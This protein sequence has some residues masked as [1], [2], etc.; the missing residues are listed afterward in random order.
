MITDWFKSSVLWG[1]S[2]WP[3]LC[4]CVTTDEFSSSNTHSLRVHLVSNS[5][6]SVCF[7]IFDQYL[8]TF[9]SLSEK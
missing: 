1:Y 5:E 9:L 7:Y 3:T 4:A 8:F 6:H 2:G